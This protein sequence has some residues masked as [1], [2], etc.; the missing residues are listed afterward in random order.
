M[1]RL[2]KFMLVGFAVAVMG[3]ALGAALP[4]LVKQAAAAGCDPP[5]IMFGRYRWCGYFY[6]RFEDSGVE[7][8][9]AGVPSSV[10]N[11]ADFYNLM[12]GDYNSGDSHKRTAVV[13]VVRTMIGL[14]LPS[15]CTP[16]S[17]CK[18]LSSA[19]WTEF[20]NRLNAYASTSENGSTSVGPNGRIAW[21]LSDYM[22]CGDYNSYYQPTPHDIAPY[23]I[24]KSNTPEC[25]VSSTR[26]DHIVIY[27]TAGN[28]VW[29]IRRLCMNPLGTIR[30][31]AAAPPQYNLTASI[32]ASS[33]G[34]PLTSGSY[35]QAGDPI[36]FNYNVNNSRTGTATGISCQ[37]HANTT[38]GWR[39][40]P[41]P[42][43]TT[44]P[45]PG[46]VT[47]R[48]TFGPGNTSLGTETIASSTNDTSVCRSLIISP[49]SP[50]GGQSAAQVCVYVSSRPYFRAY[51]GDVS[52]GNAQSNACSTVTR[53][54]VVGWNKD[55]AT[56][57]YA[58]AGA[59]FAV[60]AL[61]SI[62]QFTS[63]LGNAN[64][65][66]NRPSG[67]AFANTT[68]SG[69]RYGGSFGALPCQPDYY[70]G[71]NGTTFAGGDISSLGTGSYRATGPITISGNVNPNDRIVLYVDGNVVIDGTGIKYPGSWDVNS[72][73]LFQLIVRGDI[74]IDHTVSQ[75]D[76]I[77]IAQSGGSSGTGTIYTCT[78]GSTPY[79]VSSAG[80]FNDPCNDNTLV[81]NGAVVAKQIRLMRTR[82]TVKQANAGEASGSG[83]QAEVFNYSPA[84]W[85][86]V[87][88]N[89]T[90]QAK[91]DSI[92]SLPPIL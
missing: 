81:F 60:L 28:V 89:A 58:G 73:P 39:A 27:D 32:T 12:W 42:A 68:A 34:A 37:A 66:T 75:L 20:R 24:S 56:S 21:F 15:G 55:N 25:D 41:S 65:A 92:T 77:Y 86:A 64:A 83:N 6:N 3:S 48:D 71:V 36:T 29:K 90:S 19:N 1:N 47:C 18:T 79:T 17:S 22:H 16:T 44:G 31:L 61:D 49:S 72:M 4:A 80:T 26:F 76:G 57:A 23:I 69:S 14:P 5:A 52:A 33:G 40:I 9:L 59:Q 30:P 67:L 2:R 88:P 84:V 45:N 91:Y 35:V 8:R 43:E 63:N 53:A 38:G 10:N 50:T 7:V 74:F 51:G 46:G 70:A 78:N 62:Y 85:M 13:F 54:G 87:P 11:V 82:G